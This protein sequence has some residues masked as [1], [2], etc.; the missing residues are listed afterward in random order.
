[1]L[2][3]PGHN[4]IPKAQFLACRA[5]KEDTARQKDAVELVK[6]L[7]SHISITQGK[8]ANCLVE[9][10]SLPAGKELMYC[11]G[12]KAAMFCGKDCLRKYWSDGHKFD[13]IKRN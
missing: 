3:L 13:C 9:S 12:C 11:S 4:V 1:M 6:Y 7:E 10:D 2:N 5:A 8:C